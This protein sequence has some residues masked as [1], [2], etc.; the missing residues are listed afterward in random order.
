MTM[1]APPLLAG[2]RESCAIRCFRFWQSPEP[3]A[4]RFGLGVRRFLSALLLASATPAAISADAGLAAAGLAPWLEMLDG[5]GLLGDAGAKRALD[6]EFCIPA[7]RAL[8]SEVIAVDP[9]ARLLR[10]S[11]GRIG[12]G[13]GQWLV[14]GTTHQPGFSDVIRR[15]AELPYVERIE[16]AFYE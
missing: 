7:S 13:P 12:C 6:Y 9:S 4:A 3:L 10:G 1:H 2:D 15:L 14:L 5:N 16:P 8:A 11:P